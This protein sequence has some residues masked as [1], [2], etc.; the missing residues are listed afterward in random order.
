MSGPSVSAS[1]VGIVAGAPGRERGVLGR[2]VRALA[3]TAECVRTLAH[4]RRRHARAAEREQSDRCAVGPAERG[5]VDHR[6]HEHGSRDHDRDCV[7]LDQLQRASGLPSVHQHR[8]DRARD[9]EQYAVGESGDVRHGHGEQQRLTRSHRVGGG[10][11]V[12]LDP[13]RLMRVDDALRFGG[14]ARGPEDDR[15]IVDRDC[16]RGPNCALGQRVV[17]AH[18]D[19]L[20]ARARRRAPAP[21]SRCHGTGS[22]PRRAARSY[23]RG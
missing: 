14:R 19:D 20:A 22:A 1:R 16:D 17:A 3:P 10:D 9:G 11:R 7:A 12:G 6:P 8:R 21:D 23:D 18:D 4:H 13:Q 2:S 5:V 15:G